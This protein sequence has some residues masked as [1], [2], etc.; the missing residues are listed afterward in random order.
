MVM[1]DAL[2][3]FVDLRMMRNLWEPS[4]QA[5]SNAQMPCL[6]HNQSFKKI[7]KRAEDKPATIVAG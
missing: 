2:I 4:M 7:P 5:F 6:L 1:F 3:Q